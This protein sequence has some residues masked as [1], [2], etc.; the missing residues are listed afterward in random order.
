MKER[1]T[2]TYAIEGSVS[3][4]ETKI[5]HAVRKF[6]LPLALQHRVS[7][8]RLI[9]SV[10]KGCYYAKIHFREKLANNIK[11]IG[12][13]GKSRLT[14]V[15]CVNNDVLVVVEMKFFL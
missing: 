6:F 5:K 4:I 11:H 9:P 14:Q 2:F 1:N 7:T 10:K 15:S 3:L 8:V 13:G 12:H